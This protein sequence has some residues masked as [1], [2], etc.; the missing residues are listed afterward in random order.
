M[1]PRSTGSAGFAA[2]GGTSPPHLLL[3][4]ALAIGI[5]LASDV[6]D[7]GS[8][9][10]RLLF[11]S[12]LA[13][14]D[15]ELIATLVAS[16]VVLAAAAACRRTWIASGF[17]PQ[18]APALGLRTQAGRLASRRGHRCR[19]H[20]SGRRG[21][22]SPGLGDPGDARGDRSPRDPKRR[23]AGGERRERLPLP[24]GSADCSSPSSWTSRPGPR[25]PCSAA[26]SLRCA[27]LATALAGRAAEGAA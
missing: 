7:S 12:L 13:I 17:D 2:W 5:I 11:G 4:A 16:V 18:V 8:G 26:R 1:R 14:G 6:F 23:L 27:A 24:R 22:R 19:R 25:S 20:R 21:R 9:V 15:D 3:V 10:D